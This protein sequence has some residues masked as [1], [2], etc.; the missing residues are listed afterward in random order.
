[1]RADTISLGA[2]QLNHCSSIVFDKR[3]QVI[4][5]TCGGGS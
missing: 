4:R 5:L 3:A 1:M 2:D